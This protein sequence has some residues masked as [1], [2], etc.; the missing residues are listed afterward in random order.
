MS[1]FL[2]ACSSTTIVDNRFKPKPSVTV[3]VAP[4]ENGSTA[5]PA[6]GALPRTEVLSPQAMQRPVQPAR[7][8]ADGSQIPVVKNFLSA[9]DQAMARGDFAAANSSLERAQ[10]LAPQSVAVYQRL[11]DIRFRQGKSAESEQFAKKALAYTT[12]PE[13]QAMLWRMIARAQLQQGKM[14]SAQESL[15]RAVQLEGRVSEP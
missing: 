5:T 3:P 12:S 6:P 10:R 8:L 1:L 11:S 4:A 7:Q 2:A 14:L 13:Q 9:A 15:D